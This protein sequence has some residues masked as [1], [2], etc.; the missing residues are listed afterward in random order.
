MCLALMSLVFL[1]PIFFSFGIMQ[2][3]FFPVCAGMIRPGATV[4]PLIV[5]CSLVSVCVLSHLY[6]CNVFYVHVHV[7][8]LIFVLYF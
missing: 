5:W 3:D 8:L 1:M 4:Q 7:S 2:A 6:V